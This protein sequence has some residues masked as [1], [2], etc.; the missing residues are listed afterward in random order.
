MVDARDDTQTLHEHSAAAG[1]GAAGSHDH[2]HGNDDGSDNGT[3]GGYVRFRE[4][5]GEDSNGM[6]AS[7]SPPP[8]EV[9][10]ARFCTESIYGY[11][12][13]GPREMSS[14]ASSTMAGGVSLYN[15]H[16]TGNT[17]SDSNSS[18]QN[19][20]DA[21]PRTMQQQQQEQQ[22]QQQYRGLDFVR[23]IRRGLDELE[24]EQQLRDAHRRYSQPDM[25]IVEKYRSKYDFWANAATHRASDTP[26]AANW[27]PPLT[28]SVATA[29]SSLAMAVTSTSS[30]SSMSSLTNSPMLV[31]PQSSS[32]GS[33]TAPT[34]PTSPT[35]TGSTSTNSQS[36]SNAFSPSKRSQSSSNLSLL[37]RQIVAM[38]FYQA[39]LPEETDQNASIQPIDDVAQP[40]PRRPLPV[41]P[42]TGHEQDDQ[43]PRNAPPPCAN[44]A[45]RYLRALHV[46]SR[47]LPQHQGILTT[48][49]DG[50]LLLFNDAACLCMGITASFTGQS[51]FTKFDDASRSIVQELLQY[52]K[53]RRRSS[54]PQAAMLP[55][56][57]VLMCGVILTIVKEQGQKSSASFWLKEK[58]NQ[59]QGRF[60]YLWIF[61]EIYQSQLT[62][63]LDNQ[64][65]IVDTH[66]GTL[67]ELYEYEKK[68]VIGLS[69]TTLL[70]SLPVPLQ[71]HTMAKF[72]ASK[73]KSGR[74]FPS[75]IAAHGPHKVLVTS[76][77][78]I[79]G[80]FTVYRSGMVQSMSPVPAKYLFG[81]NTSDI[82]EAMHIDQLV[83]AFMT[84]VNI[85]ETTHRLQ[86]YRMVTHHEC[87]D[88]LLASSDTA[89]H[90]KRQLY[91]LHRDG[92][93]FHVQLQVR[94]V[95]SDGQD[96]YSAW[97]TF[98]R[99]ANDL[100]PATASSTAVHR[101]YR[102][103]KPIPPTSASVPVITGSATRV[104]DMK[105]ARPAISHTISAPIAVRR[106]EQQDE[107]DGDTGRRSTPILSP[108]TPSRFQCYGSVPR[109]KA[110]FPML[111]TPTSAPVAL[112]FPDLEDY[113][114]IDTLGEGAY[115]AAWLVHLKD[116]AKQE[117]VI[118]AIVKSRIII[119][120]WIRDRRY[121]SL[122][123]EIHI[124]L[125][126]QK[127][128]HVNCPQLVKF[129]EDEDNYY[130]VTKVHGNGMDLF[131]YIELNED[132]TEG[133]VRQIFRQVAA[134]VQHLHR[135]HI[136]HRD[137]KDANILLD[138]RGIIQLIDF[139]SAAYYRE[140]RCFDTFSGTLDYCAPEI[141]DGCAYAG[142]PQD[143]WSLGILLYTLIYRETPFYSVD[144]I[145]ER[146]LH[147]PYHPYPELQVGPVDL[148]YKMLSH[149]VH[150]RPT[151]DQIMQDPWLC[152]Y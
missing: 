96:L 64:G 61:E 131:D 23:R 128:S 74:F 117:F 41:H 39:S 8:D 145:M 11:S 106:V 98:N 100:A 132:M 30:P 69:I 82:V 99:I 48:D 9:D 137:I 149:E 139:G 127:M 104:D 75:M 26:T 83:P 24:E 49:E 73:S 91:A 10:I 53:F 107:A 142:P 90:H 121:G 40:H 134:A 62:L 12:F 36:A 50:H 143:V 116:D 5:H 94:L 54:V 3:S 103:Q 47:F 113:V 56:G 120:S 152:G 32:A 57:M 141:L 130:T 42:L 55:T 18:N 59:E 119:D 89:Q 93:H 19:T 122:P 35:A 1:A 87:R 133:Q 29:A 46:P 43:R 34:S 21:Y 37:R 58:W 108:S 78:N 97:I 151:I 22:Q 88:A 129:M 114:A 123:M 52:R 147:L 66:A 45:S 17:K 95:E 124:L 140:G 146:N 44:P 16:S 144:D 31:R 79:S 86:H 27:T 2:D 136:V 105:N 125:K 118:K 70:P 67:R 33:T 13:K 25:G 84:L 92:N 150:E 109:D 14:S 126:L 6:R 80:M 138:E 85:L 60:I 102:E 101:V 111:K 110:L 68:E 115:G 81:Y 76:L 77:P 135:L 7:R 15:S 65:T 4:N 51:I 112:G 28:K 63:R 38:S 148:L 71:T 20:A 72:Y